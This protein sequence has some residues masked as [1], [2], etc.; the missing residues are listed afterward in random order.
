VT[1]AASPRRRPRQLEAPHQRALARWLD[2]CGVVWLHVP[3][4]G[5]RSLKSGVWLKQQG[6]KAGFPDNLILT[7]PPLLPEAPG[8]A[9]ELK[10][11]LTQARYAKPSEAQGRWLEVLRALGWVVIVAHGH[12]QAI[13]ELRRL[14]YNES[15]RLERR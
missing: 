8:V 3:N 12:D 1:V 7:R 14:G 6:A 15:M 5:A 4:G 9:L 11:T 2:L 13:T 10:P